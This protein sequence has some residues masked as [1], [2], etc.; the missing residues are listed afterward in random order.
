MARQLFRRLQMLLAVRTGE[1]EFAHTYTNEMPVRKVPKNAF[2]C[3][4][5]IESGKPGWPTLAQ[6]KRGVRSREPCSTREKPMGVGLEGVYA[7][8]MPINFESL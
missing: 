4:E 6:A 2:A 1:F 5:F 3:V 7:L 8:P